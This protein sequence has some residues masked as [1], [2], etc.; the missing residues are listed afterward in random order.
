MATWSA[1]SGYMSVGID[2]SYEGDPDRGWVNVHAIVYARSDGYGH[3]FSSTWSWWGDCGSG[4]EGFSFS[5]GYGAT[6]TKVISDWRFSVWTAYGQSK[7]IKV[8]A[9]L[10][11]I[12]NGG[13][14]SVEAWIQIPARQYRA[15]GAPSAVTATRQSE[16]QVLVSWTLP[17]A[18]TEAPV[19]QIGV[20]RRSLGDPQ[21]KQM[22]W[23]TDPSATSWTD[24]AMPGNDQVEYRVQ[25][26]NS[27]GYSAHA[28]ASSAVTSSV[29]A[30]SGVTAAKDSS[31]SIIV[32]WL[33]NYP[34]G[35]AFEVFDNGVKVGEAPVVSGVVPSFTH[36]GPDP[37]VTHT[38]TVKQIDGGVSS[39]LSAPSPTVQLLAKPNP[40]RL[41]CPAGTVQSGAVVLEWDH[42]P[43]DSTS[44]SAAEIRYRDRGASSWTTRSLT[45][46]HQLSV[47][48]V[49]G[50]YEWQARTKG[51]HAEFSAWSA[52]NAFTVADVP[53]VTISS[54][55]GGATLNL[56][57]CAITWE[58]FQAQG[59]GQSAAEAELLDASGAV[60]ERAQVSGGAKTLS[61]S[62]PLTDAASYSTRVRV[63]SG[64]GLWSTWAEARFS[65]SFPA[66][67]VPR[68][69]ATWDEAQG[70]AV[71]SIM[72]EAPLPTSRTFENRVYNPRMVLNG[73]GGIRGVYGLE[74][75][76]STV[77]RSA[78]NGGAEIEVLKESKAFISQGGIPM[79]RGKSYVLRFEADGEISE[80]NRRT[81]IQHAA[82]PYTNIYPADSKDEYTRGLNILTFTIPD[83]ESKW[84]D[85]RGIFVIAIP[86][87]PGAKIIFDRL[88]VY[89]PFESE[90]EA[91]AYGAEYFD[92]DSGP[93]ATIGGQSY[94]VRWSGVP[95]FSTTIGTPNSP[96]AVSNRVERSVD[97]GETWE[98]VADSVAISSSVT[99]RE[100]LSA[101]TTLYRVSALT[102][103]PSSSSRI[104][105]LHADSDAVWLS[106]GRGFSTAVP[107]NWDPQHSTAV[108][109]VNRKVHYFAGRRLGVE[110]SGTQRKRSVSVSA[111]LLDERLDLIR[112]LEELSYLPAPFLYRDPLGRRIYGSLS[113]VQMD[114]AVGGKW[115][116]AAVVEE[117]ERR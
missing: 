41:V 23:L 104:I 50:S 77:V 4:S 71:L 103:L 63:R 110:M 51:L 31:G 18:S 55:V 20:Q 87:R 39:P 45:T 15:P 101:G 102:D 48:L 99:D 10:G 59:A 115:Q 107:L 22:V 54:P 17:G 113:G 100:S 74:V 8:G 3:S 1:S 58:F 44:Q 92:G 24:T 33:A 108:G 109:L 65:V 91:H 86:K 114:R 96:A 64:H 69:E 60:V 2:L 94:S 72:N 34:G 38:Y 52:V 85:N 62:T 80:L 35:G 83:D 90:D 66:P 47:T 57:R 56:S 97:G 70:L 46:A 106:G 84:P 21:W 82:S 6:V 98:V 16:K 76:T 42:N 67:P 7:W 28:D 37:Q 112:R 81:Y 11:P 73:N 53:T 117:V 5:S 29:A 79:L 26:W 30:P 19:Q 89:G 27:G 78:P 49:A 95:N 9:S 25:T 111:T 68:A 105:E 75:G 43:V 12:W 32:S 116:V 40:P 93:N 36:V 14:P 61:F 13:N 88:G